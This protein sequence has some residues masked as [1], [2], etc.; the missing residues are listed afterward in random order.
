[1]PDLTADSHSKKKS[2]QYILAGFII[3]TLRYYN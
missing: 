3:V 1:M 2:P